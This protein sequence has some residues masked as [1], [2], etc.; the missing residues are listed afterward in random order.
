MTLNGFW[1]FTDHLYILVIGAL[2]AHVLCPFLKSHFLLN[3]WIFA[4]AGTCGSCLSVWA[5]PLPGSG[6]WFPTSF[7]SWL[8]SAI[9]ATVHLARLI[10]DWRFLGRWGIRSGVAC[11]SLLRFLFLFL[12]CV[13]VLLPLS[14]WQ[15]LPSFLHVPIPLRSTFWVFAQ[16]CGW[17]PVPSVSVGVSSTT[18]PSLKI[19]FSWVLSFSLQA[20]CIL[21]LDWLLPQTTWKLALGGQPVVFGLRS[22]AEEAV[23]YNHGGV[24]E[25]SGQKGR[26]Q[27]W[28]IWRKYSQAIH[29]I[30]NWIALVLLSN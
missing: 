18:S 21:F 11:F 3:S 5:L 19:S 7:S 15:P 28:E 8:W 9:V 20:F 12:M 10:E 6:I 22:R 14:T 24:P 16:L 29:C 27:N 13:Y 17:F 2:S 26:S 30:C 23:T 25:W 1:M 4:A